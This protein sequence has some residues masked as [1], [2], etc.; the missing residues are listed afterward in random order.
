MT[1]FHISAFRQ[2]HKRWLQQKCSFGIQHVLVFRLLITRFQTVN[3][4]LQECKV[5]YQP[6][7]DIGCIY[8]ICC[9]IVAKLSNQIILVLN[10]G[11]ISMSCSLDIHLS[12]C[13]SLKSIPYSSIIMTRLLWRSDIKDDILPHDCSSNLPFDIVL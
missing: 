4:I 3:Q 8:N 1:C 9:N 7:A 13:S 10:V 12:F 6:A 11:M 2:C 5:L